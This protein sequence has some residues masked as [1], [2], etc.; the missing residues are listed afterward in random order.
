[1]LVKTPKVE[2][3]TGV[4]ETLVKS[5]E[6]VRDLG[7][8]YTPS[9]MVVEMLNLLPKETWTTHPSATFLEPSC[10][11]GNF[12][13]AV[14]ERKYE[15]AWQEWR[16]SSQA[17]SPQYFAR[18]LLE[19]LSSV[20]GVDISPANIYGDPHTHPVGAIQRVTE[21]ALAW[22]DRSIQETAPLPEELGLQVAEAIAWIVEANIQLGN[23]L[24]FNNDGTPSNRNSMPLVEYRWTLDDFDRVAIA[25]T[26]Y[27]ETA[28]IALYTANP[29]V[30]L[31][32]PE[33]P[34][35]VWQDSWF[36]LGNAPKPRKNGGKRPRKARKVSQ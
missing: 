32:E 1:M 26:T 12:V 6:R 10:G 36:N 4:S 2:R 18:L 7:E 22:L 25:H 31:F 17:E 14:L 3:G 5:S 27:G 11:D 21:Q 23:M 28:E 20:Y 35:T 13:V 34:A 19:A 15:Q 30:M 24:P 8:V 16:D 9:W 29:G 33:P